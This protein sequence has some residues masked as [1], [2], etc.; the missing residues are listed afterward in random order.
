[1]SRVLA[2]DLSTTATGVVYG[3]WGALKVEEMFTIKPKVVKAPTIVDP[4]MKSAAQERIWA[5]AMELKEHYERISVEHGHPVVVIEALQSVRNA[6]TTR[7]LAML[8]GAVQVAFRLAGCARVYWVHQGTAK[9]HIGAVGGKAAVMKR[10]KGL[11]YR[12]KTQD[13]AD[14]LCVWLA[15]KHGKPY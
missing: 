8:H 2:L 1:M 11:G 4:L 15:A 12:P 3:D 10:V 6:R 7:L 13:E 5:I 14:A 9:A